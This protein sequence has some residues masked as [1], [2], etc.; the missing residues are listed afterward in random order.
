MRSAAR[1]VRVAHNRRQEQENARNLAIIDILHG[2]GITI[3]LYAA[4]TSDNVARVKDLLKGDPALVRTK[5]QEGKPLLDRAIDLDRREIVVL[6]LDAGADPNASDGDKY[7]VLHSAAF[8]NRLEIAK[9]L[10]ER[11]ADVNA[12]AKDGFTPLHEAA[13]LGS[14]AVARLLIGARRQDQRHRQGWQNSAKLG[15]RGN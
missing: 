5:D 3:D 6:L 15:R 11:H 13:R 2:H 4:I 10:I 7:T 9:L 8:W 1:E 12:C 14:V